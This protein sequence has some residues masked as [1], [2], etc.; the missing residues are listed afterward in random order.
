MNHPLDDAGA[1]LGRAKH[2]LDVLDN[3]IRVWQSGD[4]YPIAHEYDADQRRHLFI[5]NRV[6]AMP[7]RDW[8]LIV[9][10][11][12]H[13]ARAALDYLAWQLAGAD[14]A[15]TATQFPIFNDPIL[16]KKRGLVM[17]RRLSPRAQTLVKWLQP[18]RGSDPVRRRLWLLQQLDIL[19]KH[20]LLVVVYG[21]TYMARLRFRLAPLQTADKWIYTG[22][23]LDDRTVLAVVSFDPPDAADAQVPVKAKLPLGVAFGE[24]FPPPGG[25]FLVTR[26]LR[27]LI[28]A[29]ESTMA[30]FERCWPKI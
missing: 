16:F 28:A 12:I 22:P 5:A 21:H 13:N 6:Q 10:D 18:H 11:C 17:I 9:G 1:K 29:A 2:H 19:D 15:D 27:D 8:S 23:F 14:P 30:V 7:A 20:K 25:P 4:P 24:G 3:E 26:T